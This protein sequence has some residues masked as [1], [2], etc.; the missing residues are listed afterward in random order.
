MQ[1]AFLKTP[2]FNANQR[3]RNGWWILLF[4]VLFLLSRFV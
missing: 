3:L 1:D 4:V 2:F